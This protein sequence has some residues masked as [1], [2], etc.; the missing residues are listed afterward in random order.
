MAISFAK[1]LAIGASSG[2]GADTGVDRDPVDQQPCR[3]D[4]HH[5]VSQPCLH[6]LEL[7]DLLAELTALLHGPRGAV[8]R[9]LPDRQRHR[10]VAQRSIETAVNSFG[11]P[12]SGTMTSSTG[13]RASVSTMPADPMPREPISSSCGPKLTPGVSLSASTAPIPLTR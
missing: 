2:L 3:L 13:T 11:N 7:D 5:Y 8:E 1:H 10:R 9:G 4:L 12:P 6:G